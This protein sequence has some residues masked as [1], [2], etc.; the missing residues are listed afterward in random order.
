MKGNTEARRTAWLYWISELFNNLLFT[1]PIWVAFQGRFMTF[2][3]MSFFMTIRF[4]ISFILEL[5]TGAFADLYGRKTS[6]IVGSTICGISLIV[7]AFSSSAAQ[8][9]VAIMLASIGESFISGANM[10]LLFDTLKHNNAANQFSYVRSRGVFLAQISI[11]ISSI[12]SGYLYE[13]WSGLPYIAE[14][15]RI[16]GVIACYSLIND[17]HKRAKTISL[18]SYIQKTKNGFKE[19]VQTPYITKLSLFYIGVG[20][21]TWSWQQFFN[22]IYA[23]AIG[24]SD[25]QKGWLFGVIRLVNAILLITIFTRSIFTKS[26]IFLLFPL[27]IIVTAL[28]AP[29]NN[30]PLGTMLLLTM[31]MGSSLRFSI[32]DGYVNEEFASHHRATALSSLNM[33]VK[34]GYMG[35]LTVSGLF[36]DHYFTGYVY[37]GMGILAIVTILPLGIKLARVSRKGHAHALKTTG[38]GGT[39]LIVDDV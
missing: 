20:A 36:L 37:A 25:I 7:T 6:I 10:A 24:Y 26:V 19:L 15:I 23:T 21:I 13:I 32:L 39:K 28:L 38:I 27:L 35:V 33:L 5:P 1:I 34:L 2:S 30:L 12:F 4:V 11:V 22:Q 3:M 17:Y 14:L 16:V 29:I 9:L 31:T 8:F 18:T